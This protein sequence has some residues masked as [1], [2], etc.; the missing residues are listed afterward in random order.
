MR[1][2]TSCLLPA[3]VPSSNLI[4]DKKG[5]V[6]AAWRCHHSRHIPLHLQ[7]HRNFLI[8]LKGILSFD[9]WRLTSDQKYTIRESPPYHLIKNEKGMLV[10]LFLISCASAVSAFNALG[11]LKPKINVKTRQ[12][13]HSTQ[14]K[15]FSLSEDA[16]TSFNPLAITLS[17]PGHAPFMVTP[18]STLTHINSINNEERLN[19]VGDTN[20]L[21]YRKLY[22]P[23]LASP[24]PSSYPRRSKILPG[25]IIHFGSRA[26][27]IDFCTLSQHATQH[28][29]QTP[30]D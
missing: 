14:S 11:L 16:L 12:R 25:F 2:S 10:M 4:C 28:L 22:R 29:T 5:V 6:T 26:N 8:W 18:S 9:R 24:F 17:S 15:G 7:F 23:H 30:P 13:R 27:L 1:N 20:T 21:P 3:V 19:P